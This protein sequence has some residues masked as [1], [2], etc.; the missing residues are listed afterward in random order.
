MNIT[1]NYQSWASKHT[2]PDTWQQAQLDVDYQLDVPSGQYE[3][4]M[5]LV[6]STPKNNTLTIVLNEAN[7]RKLRDYLNEELS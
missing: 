7:A 1:A 2:E 6:R 5:F 4:T 3:L